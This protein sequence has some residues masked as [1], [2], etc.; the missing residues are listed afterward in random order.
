[1]SALY[2]RPSSTIL[3]TRPRFSSDLIPNPSA[4]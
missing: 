1:M 4:T 3:D 2:P